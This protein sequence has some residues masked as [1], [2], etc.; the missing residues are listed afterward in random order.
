MT[1]SIT[2]YEKILNAAASLF[3]TRGIQASGVDTIIAEAG[4]AKATLYKHFP[5]K[6]ELVMAYL[7][8]KSD[9]FYAWLNERLSAKKATSLEILFELCDLVE[10][11]I[12]TPEFHGL[13]FHIASVEF[14]D[15]SHPINQYSSVLAIELQHYLSKIAAAAGAKD[16]EALGQ[17]LTIL[18]E[19]AALV[20]R[21]SP[22]SDAAKRAKNAAVMLIHA[23]I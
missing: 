19:G 10:I 7:R 11:W 3:E 13:P 5:S 9:K 12:S 1:N 17:Q 23:S 8:D 21:L 22:S 15:P 6:N 2:M 4:V 14:P 20:E 16:P 18:F